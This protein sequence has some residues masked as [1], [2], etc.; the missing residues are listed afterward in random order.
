[1]L[2]ESWL[3]VVLKSPNVV[4]KLKGGERDHMRL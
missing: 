1:L 2:K 4:T 3:T